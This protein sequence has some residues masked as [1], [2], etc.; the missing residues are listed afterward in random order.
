MG[1]RGAELDDSRKKTSDALA[2]TQRAQKLAPLEGSYGAGVHH[3]YDGNYDTPEAQDSLRRIAE[4]SDKS[5][6]LGGFLQEDGERMS[7]ALKLLG[8]QDP[9][10]RQRLVERYGFAMQSDGGR[11]DRGGYYFHGTPEY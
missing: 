9:E 4:K 8:I 11:N 2:M 3:I 7:A 1:L 10:I 6:F 5:W